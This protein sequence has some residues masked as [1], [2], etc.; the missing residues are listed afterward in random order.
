[1][2]PLTPP[3]AVETGDGLITG[4]ID[5]T[6]RMDARTPPVQIYSRS[7]K[8]QA[9]ANTA[10]HSYGKGIIVALLSFKLAIP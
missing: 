1:M 9:K 5:H 6:A 7:Y 4:F 2:L 10:G 3:A 8:C